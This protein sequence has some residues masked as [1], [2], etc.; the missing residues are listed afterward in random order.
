MAENKDGFTDGL[1]QLSTFAATGLSD[2]L[3]ISSAAGETRVLNLSKQPTPDILNGIDG[4]IRSK[5]PDLA[6]TWYELAEVNRISYEGKTL[7]PA[8]KDLKKYWTE[9]GQIATDN[10]N[11]PTFME[12]VGGVSADRWTRDKMR[13]GVALNRW[14]RIT[15]SQEA[16]LKAALQANSPAEIAAQDYTAFSWTGGSCLSVNTGDSDWVHL[17][18]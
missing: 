9:L 8:H 5:Y 14:F 12:A 7:S 13:N 10:R 17:N 15:S 16:G 11:D 6:L 1:D 18:K 2:N 4:Y 3:K